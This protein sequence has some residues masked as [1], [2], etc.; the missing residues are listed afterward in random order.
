MMFGTTLVRAGKVLLRQAHKGLTYTPAQIVQAMYHGILDRAPDEAGK[1]GLLGYL[2]AGGS[3]ERALREM[4][5][6]SESTMKRLQEVLPPH[7]LPDLRTIAPDRFSTRRVGADTNL[8]FEA[9]GAADFDLLETWIRTYR[10]YDVPGLWG[11]RIDLDKCVTAAIVE[12]LG[13]RS[14]LEIGCFTGPVL[15]LLKERGIDVAGLDASHLAFVLAYPSIRNDMR[16]G[17][18]LEVE[19]GRRFDAVVAMDILEHL[20]P[21]RFGRYLDRIAD[22]LAPDGYLVLNSPMFG[23]DDMFGT[24]FPQYIDEWRATGDASHWNILDCD[25]N[26]WPKHGHLIWASPGWWEATLARHGLVR[27]RD[28]EAMLQ[29][30]L[31]G[32]FATSSSRKCLFILKHAAGT[33]SSAAA[34]ARLE[35]T[36]GAV[37][38]LPE[39][40]PR[41]A[42]AGRGAS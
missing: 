41:H 33:Q 3:L 40:V 24:V 1:D 2:E 35:K 31:A 14:C 29:D 19:F 34:I 17:D 18:L 36:L 25:G 32:F 16:F 21:N 4:L 22:L 10:Y 27:D 37:A 28:I 8:L 20:N 13:A 23:T 9:S 42:R 38:G 26:G 30:R 12:G 6:S 7:T 5:Q 15:S 39:G 11:A